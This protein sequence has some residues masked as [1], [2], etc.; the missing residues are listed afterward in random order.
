[1]SIGEIV[2]LVI[3]NAIWVVPFLYE[4]VIVPIFEY[5]LRAKEEKQ[6]LTLEGRRIQCIHCSYC[7][8]F[9]YRPFYHSYIGTTY[10]P[11]YC[12]K[13]KIKLKPNINLICQ[14]F[15]P[16]DAEREIT[17]THYHPEQGLF[18]P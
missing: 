3:I 2:L 14:A 5:V 18:E 13:L 10:T 6:L 4:I 8:K 11:A 16:E 9:I 7:H 17:S 1:M 15:K 12:R